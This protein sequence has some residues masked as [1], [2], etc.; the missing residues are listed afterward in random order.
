M[1]AA[2]RAL[3][4]CALLAASAQ[5][6]ARCT[7]PHVRHAARWRTRAAWTAVPTVGPAPA[8]RARDGEGGA[9]ERP[10]RLARAARAAEA[11]W[12]F[13]RPHTLIGSAM[14]IPALHLFAAPAGVPLPWSALG[15]SIAFVLAPSLLINVYI[16]GLNQVLDISADKIN[17]PYLPLAK[18]EFSR[19]QGIAICV[20]CLVVGLALGFAPAT[21]LASAPLKATLLGSTLLGTAYS[22][23]PLRLKRFPLLASLCITSVRGALVNWGFFAHAASVVYGLGAPSSSAA[24]AAAAFRCGCATAFFLLFGVVIAL[25]KDIPDVAGDR[26][27][28]TATYSL[29]FGR[30]RVFAVATAL[31]QLAYAAVALALGA[32]AVSGLAAA[33]GAAGAFASAG[34]GG[35]AALTALRRIAGSIIALA[36]A[37]WLRA[38]AATVRVDMPDEVYAFYMRCWALFYASYAW[39]PLAR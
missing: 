20:A 33:G 11:L 15:R 16:V 29:R 32:A 4:L 31:L 30:A 21:P 6:A 2:P 25:L 24:A 37:G 19:E 7:A 10:A 13:T 12:N 34:A 1:R 26:A 36:F 39:L 3:G 5:G 14:S 18:G 22:M 35:T 27:V 38:R 8:E 28:G 9:V 23:P 17:K